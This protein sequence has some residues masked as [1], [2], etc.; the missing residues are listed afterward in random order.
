MKTNRKKQLLRMKR[1]W[2]LYTFLI[3][4]LVYIIVFK[5]VPMGGLVIAFKD[6]K[7]RF[8]IWGS[9]WVGFEH[10]IRFFKSYQFKRVISNTLILSFYNIIAGFPLP[11]IFA[12]LLNSVR[13]ERFKKITQSIACLPHFIST[14]VLVGIVF[15]IFNSRTGLYGT[16]GEWLTGSYPKDIMGSPAVFRH[17][18]VWSGIWKGFGWGSIIYTAALAGVDPTYHE[19]AQI[20]GATRFQRIIHI[21]LPSIAPTIITMLI[22]RLG[23][24]MSIGFEKTYLMQNSLNISASEVISTYSYSVGLAGGANTNMSYAAAIGF[25]NSIVNL[26]MLVTANKLARKFSETSLW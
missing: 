17:M 7:P 5:Y 19:A 4:P 10:F 12:L 25:F 6:F 22:L 26:I 18:Y 2:R 21:D 9:E 20:D 1:D 11:I 24:V 16:I 15:Q 3:I 8:G 13:N 14:V 23:D